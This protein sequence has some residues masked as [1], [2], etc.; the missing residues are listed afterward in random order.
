MAAWDLKTG[1]PVL[2][3]QDVPLMI[4]PDNPVFD[5]MV[6][7]VNLQKVLTW[8]PKGDFSGLSGP[9]RPGGHTWGRQPGSRGSGGHKLESWF[10]SINDLVFTA[11]GGQRRP[12]AAERSRRERLPFGT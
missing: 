4:T 9:G 11:D 6:G 2:I 5:A 1:E 12:S 3:R 10:K 8:T 7:G